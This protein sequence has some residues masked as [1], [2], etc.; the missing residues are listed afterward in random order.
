MERATT[1]GTILVPF[2][3]TSIWHATWRSSK[4]EEFDQL[5]NSKCMRHKTVYD[6]VSST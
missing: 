1:L 5:V 2:L 4:Q 6:L 3:F